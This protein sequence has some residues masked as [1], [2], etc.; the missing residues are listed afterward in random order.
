MAP[1]MPNRQTKRWGFCIVAA[2]VALGWSSPVPARSL[3][4]EDPAPQA[5]STTPEKQGAAGAPA[6]QRRINQEIQITGDR[7][8]SDTG[9]DVQPGERVILAASGKLRYADAK[10]DNDPEGL[11]RDFKDLMRILPLN[12]SGRGAVIGRIGDAAVVQPFLVG[13]HHVS[14]AP[15][16]GRLAIGINQT[17]DEVGDG[18]YTVQIEVYV[19]DRGT[20]V[21]AVRQVKNIPGIDK[22]LFSKIPRRVADKDGNP[23]DMINFLIV[24]PESGVENVFSKAGWVKVDTDPTG[25]MLRAILASIS[26]EAYVTMPMSALYL[27]G[28]VQDYGWAHAEPIAVVASRN[29]LRIWKVPFQVNGQTV[30]AGA[31]T[32]DI[33]FEIDRR[34]DNI[35]HKIDPDIDLE[36]EYVEKTLT[37]TGLV[38]EVA[39]FVPENAV[40]EATTATGGSFHSDGQVVILKLNDLA[41]G[42][43]SVTS[44][45]P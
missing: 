38:A 23:G 39:R 28:R 34:N 11:P 40:K 24:G 27:F 22:S 17:A 5:A 36:R 35:T 1:D 31:A 14:T 43:S 16:G 18:T 19:A 10:E 45:G 3:C 37:A 9:I 44:A 21:A 2:L 8:W 41:Q 4:A 25:S 42:L 6:S 30:W 7:V 20:V 15:I 32:H 29:H 26:K 33:G 12:S 13:A